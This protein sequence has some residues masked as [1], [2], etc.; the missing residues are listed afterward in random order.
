MP[1]SGDHSNIDRLDDVSDK[2]KQEV[3]PV[4]YTID[5]NGGVTYHGYDAIVPPVEPVAMIGGLPQE[6]HEALVVAGYISQS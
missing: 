5:T 4:E 1:G 2:Y 6:V 3:K